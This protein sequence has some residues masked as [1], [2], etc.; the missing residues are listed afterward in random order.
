[1]PQL[2]ATPATAS[3]GHLHRHCHRNHHHH[4]CDL[5]DDGGELEEDMHDIYS[6][7][8]RKST[9]KRS[10]RSRSTS[11]PSIREDGGSKNINTDLHQQKGSM[12]YSTE[13]RTT[14]S[15]NSSKMKKETKQKQS[16]KSKKKKKESKNNGNVPK[17]P[18]SHKKTKKTT[19]VHHH[20]HHHHHHE[21]N[22]GNS[23]QSSDSTVNTETTRST[24]DTATIAHDSRIDGSDFSPSLKTLSSPSLASQ[25]SILSTRT[26]KRPHD[27][28]KTTDDV[29]RCGRSAL[30]HNHYGDSVVVIDQDINKTIGSNTVLNIG[31]ITDMKATKRSKPSTKKK[32]G[33]K[34]KKKKHDGMS[35]TKVK[36]SKKQKKPKME[37]DIP[38]TASSSKPSDELAPTSI[39]DKNVRCS[40][41]TKRNQR[42]KQMKDLKHSNVSSKQSKKKGKT[43][44]NGTSTQKKKTMT[45]KK[46]KTKTRK[47][48]ERHV[49]NEGMKADAMDAPP[50]G[51]VAEEV[52][53]VLTNLNPR[54]HRYQE[55]KKVK[56]VKS[57]AKKTTSKAPTSN[58]TRSSN[59]MRNAS[60]CSNQKSSKPKLSLSAS[61]HGN[62]IKRL[63]SWR[64]CP[65]KPRQKQQ[66]RP[67][68]TSLV[69]TKTWASKLSIE[70]VEEAE[71]CFSKSESNE[72]STF[73]CSSISQSNDIRH[74]RQWYIRKE[75]SRVKDDH[76]SERSMEMVFFDST[77]TND[78]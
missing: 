3:D 43:S 1:M 66:Q 24:T 74:H 28:T 33:K 7:S 52:P 29:G 42:K 77:V 65:W 6:T 11:L 35:N 58:A 37:N 72:S 59:V 70:I 78:C 27:N 73:T 5:V 50:V 21:E 64:L 68:N 51:P 16:S 2:S 12:S 8:R 34:K 26:T 71:S 41:S 9:S 49:G 55:G 18:K 57:S 54:K 15:T 4:Q 67:I 32:K 31:S 23:R 47:K 53:P 76:P 63:R 44:S 60:S 45:S 38:C 36:A 46:M 62:N 13:S 19:K 61:I 14:T 22:D 20:R 40:S 10:T 25:G 17:A 30:D 56:K 69:M 75:D 48:S 39:P